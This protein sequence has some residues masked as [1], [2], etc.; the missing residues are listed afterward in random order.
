MRCCPLLFM[1]ITLESR[2]QPEQPHILLI[3]GM[4]AVS[5]L[6]MEIPSLKILIDSGLEEAEQVKVR[7]EQLNLVSEK[8]ITAIYLHQLYQKRMVKAY[9][10]KVKP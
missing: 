3:Y 6:E 5:P 9:N 7:Y 10:K 2:C 4:E 1:H 8:R